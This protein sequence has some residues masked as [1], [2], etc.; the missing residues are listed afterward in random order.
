M[1]DR[2][3]SDR[4]LLNPWGARSAYIQITANWRQQ[5]VQPDCSRQLIAHPIVMPDVVGYGR[6][7]ARGTT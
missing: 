4:K 2:T 5:M 3:E 6:L 1:M 7:T